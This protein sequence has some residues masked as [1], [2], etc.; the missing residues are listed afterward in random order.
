MK[1]PVACLRWHRPIE[2]DVS[3]HGSLVLKGDI[4]VIPASRGMYVI[5]RRTRTGIMPVYVGL[6]SRSIRQRVK[7]H[8]KSD[9]M[10]EE[11]VDGR[12]SKRLFFYA[13]LTPG[14]LE[15]AKRYLPSFERALIRSAINAGG[16]TLNRHQR[17]IRSTH[18]PR[19]CS[20]V[21][22]GHRAAWIDWSPTRVTTDLLPR[23]RKSA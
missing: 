21:N 14:G 12:R 15:F 19:A 13:E 16:A 11:L 17:Q 23:R 2:I 3:K 6:A 22:A 20:F 4:S 10:I 5:A 8:L 18:I 1:T 9:R 7:Q